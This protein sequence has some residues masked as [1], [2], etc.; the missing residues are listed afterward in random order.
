MTLH[1]FL[2]GLLL[3]T[4]VQDGNSTP[5]PGE[6]VLGTWFVESDKGNIHLEITREKDIYSGRISWIEEPLFPESH[7]R[8]GEPKT[9]IYNPEESLRNRPLLDLV[10]LTGFRFYPG[11]EEW[12]DGRIYAADNGKTYRCWMRLED[13]GRLKVRGYIKVGFAK[14]G[15]SMHWTRVEELP[16][17]DPSR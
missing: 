15:R 11:K 10:L 12:K 17:M 13:D 7:P 1:P 9:D 14:I 6:A 16:E 2:L 3:L 8:A 4:A 5:P